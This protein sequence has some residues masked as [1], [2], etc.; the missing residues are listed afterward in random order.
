MSDTP[1]QCPSCSSPLVITQ[2]GCTSC[3]TVVS[4]YYQLNPFFQLPQES[5][6]FL[7]DFIRNRGNIK[8]MAR[9]SEESYWVI[10]SKL[11]KTV[12]QFRFEEDEPLPVRRKN[13]LLRLQRGELDVEQATSLLK[14]LKKYPWQV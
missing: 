2:L 7:M 13:I 9:K 5:L 11:D 3:D 8:E 6:D 14:A 1:L 12:A 4:G 10:R